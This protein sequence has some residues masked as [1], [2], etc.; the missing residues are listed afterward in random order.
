MHSNSFFLP[1]LFNEVIGE[2]PSGFMHWLL[3]SLFVFQS[4]KTFHVE[5]PRRTQHPQPN[6][7]IEECENTSILTHWRPTAFRDFRKK[8]LNARGFVR[9]FLQSNMLYRPGKSLKRRG[10]SS[11][12]HQCCS[13]S[14]FS[15]S[16]IRIFG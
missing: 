13:G 14:G 8:R 5:E 3:K 4:H 2:L 12:L 15:E 16:R 9:E 6:F 1:L 11:S 10:K 7:S